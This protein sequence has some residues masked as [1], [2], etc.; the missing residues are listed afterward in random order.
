MKLEEIGP[1]GD[2]SLALSPGSST[3]HESQL[4]A[5]FVVLMEAFTPAQFK[6]T[7]I[8]LRFFF[9]DFELEN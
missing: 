6:T 9:F 7:A 3:A 5:R 2:V 1:K 8:H 4:V